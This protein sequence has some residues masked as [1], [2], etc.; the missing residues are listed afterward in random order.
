MT[1]Q[2]VVVGVVVALALAYVVWRVGGFQQRHRRKRK[3][4]V[5]LSRL[6]RPKSPP[7]GE[8]R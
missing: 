5:P 8:G 6:R 2:H 1:W 3:P 7:E 4:D